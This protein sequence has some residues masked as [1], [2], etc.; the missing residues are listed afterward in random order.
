MVRDWIS[1]RELFQDELEPEDKGI[2]LINVQFETWEKDRV[3]VAIFAVEKIPRCPTC[4]VITVERNRCPECYR[5]V[6]DQCFLAK[7]EGRDIKP[8]DFR[9]KDCHGLKG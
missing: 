6:C 7:L 8:E 2:C 1:F 3:H 9:C 4:G 5:Y